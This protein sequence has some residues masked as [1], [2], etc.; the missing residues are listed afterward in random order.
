MSYDWKTAYLKDEADAFRRLLEL[1][2]KR[3]LCRGQSRSYLPRRLTPKIDREPREDL[4]RT[5]RL[6]IERQ[7]IELF[8]STARYFSHPGE[9]A[10]LTDDIIA[11]AV[12][13]HYGLPTRLL[14]WSQSPYVAAYF[15]ACSH[16]TQDGEIWSFD[17]LSYAQK[18]KA[19][20]KRWPE[21]TSDGS[22]ADDKFDAKLT[23]FMEEE[24][25]NWFVCMF[26]PR[27]F[28]RQNAQSGVYSLTS[29]FGRDHADAIADLLN[30]DSLYCR[31]VVPAQ[32]K[33]R[34]LLLLRERY[35]IWRG[36][37]FPDSAGAAETVDA[38]VFPKPGSK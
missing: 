2:G 22:G 8:R 15:A 29:R 36:S 11:L 4:E 10:A 6:S 20:W 17:Y 12:L 28:H 30:D 37:L 7:S 3:W 18:G 19:Q 16:D 21:T 25:P 26:Y 24:P 23:A 38:I 13:R 1:S 35:D 14:D 27:G 32:L 5:A 34:L 31:Y 9:E 33:K